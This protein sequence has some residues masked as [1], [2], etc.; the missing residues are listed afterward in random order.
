MKYG[1]H[2][3]SRVSEIRVKRIRVKQGVGV[4]PTLLAALLSPHWKQRKS[5]ETKRKL[6]GRKLVSDMSSAI[7]KACSCSRLYGSVKIF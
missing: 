3:K 1:N 4:R 5:A 6:C 2:L 7:S